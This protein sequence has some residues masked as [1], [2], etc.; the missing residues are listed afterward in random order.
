MEEIK[1]RWHGDTPE[2]K[3]PEYSFTNDTTAQVLIGIGILCIFIVICAIAAS[4]LTLV[5]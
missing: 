5:K 4:C 1:D 2:P 3:P